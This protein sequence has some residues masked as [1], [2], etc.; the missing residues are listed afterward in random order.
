MK[1][2][3]RSMDNSHS[4]IPY[5]PGVGIVLLNKEKKIFA[6]KR[7]DTH[8]EAWQMP[9][10]GINYGEEPKDAVLRELHEE[11]GVEKAKIIR[12]SSDWFYYD[13][14]NELANKLWRGRYRGQRQKWFA[15][16]FLGS[17]TDI[18]IETERPEFSEW[19]WVAPEA[20]PELIVPF[21]RL[22]Y[23]SVLKEF[24]DLW[25]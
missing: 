16:A 12:E 15:I 13:L 3:P 10:G 22:L 4:A 5:R 17:D 18:N 7:I 1:E 8:A 14:P 24:Q 23:Q 6:G 19:K 21:K 9:Q 11:T 20:L 25:N 2:Y